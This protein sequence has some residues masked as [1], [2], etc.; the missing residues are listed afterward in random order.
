MVT[1]FSVLLR[2]SVT[3]PRSF[4]LEAVSIGVLRLARM[5]KSRSASASL[6]ALAVCTTATSVYAVVVFVLFQNKSEAHSIY[7]IHLIYFRRAFKDPDGRLV[8]FA[9][10]CEL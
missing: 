4:T 8:I 5:P 10:S 2:A 1:I 9:M 7:L 6:A 3:V